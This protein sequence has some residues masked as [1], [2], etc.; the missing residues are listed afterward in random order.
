MK[1]SERVLRHLEEGKR[2]TCLNAFQELGITQVA[3]RIYELKK[4]GHPITTMPM[5]VKNRY[6]DEANVVNY[7]LEKVDAA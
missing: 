3:A 1:Q 2:L 4:E 6:G 7:V 5:K